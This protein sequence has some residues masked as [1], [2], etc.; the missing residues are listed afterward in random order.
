MIAVGVIIEVSM[1]TI[2]ASTVLLMTIMAMVM[3]C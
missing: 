2:I 3:K 1:A